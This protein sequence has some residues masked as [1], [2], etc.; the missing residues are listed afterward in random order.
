MPCAWFP[1]NKVPSG[2]FLIQQRACI[3]SSEPL[4]GGIIKT[5]DK[6]Y[7][8][9]VWTIFHGLNCCFLSPLFYEGLRAREI[10]ASA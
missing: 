7:Y 10:S 8:D 5:A 1:G 3:K 4:A 2:S 6:A 9:P